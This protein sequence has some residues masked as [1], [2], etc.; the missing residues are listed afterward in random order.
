MLTK[1]PLHPRTAGGRPAPPSP[2]A[3]PGLIYWPAVAA[4]AGL[5]LALVAGL[6]VWLATLP[7]PQRDDAAG[8]ENAAAQE[9]P[10]RT[11]AVLPRAS[12]PT[13]KQDNPA[14]A[15][16]P[17]GDVGAR[18]KSPASRSV[19][20]RREPSPPA[21]QAPHDPKEEELPAPPLSGRPAGE[22]YGTSVVFLSNPA[23]AA[24]RARQEDKLL[25]VLHV[26]GNFEE[27]CFT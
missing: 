8:G 26:S 25:F 21:D 6:F 11:Q 15:H 3:R 27:S 12:E 19:L 17:A 10:P 1:P 5:S 20:P 2:T 14:K 24:R 9:A 7:A 22:T 16:S 4:A 13:A 23:E 18:K